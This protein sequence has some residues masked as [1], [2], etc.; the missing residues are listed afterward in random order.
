MKEFGD[1]VTEGQTDPQYMF[2]AQ[3]LSALDD[4]W[5][6]LLQMWDSRQQGL[7]Q[8]L[9]LQVSPSPNLKKYIWIFY[10]LT[11]KFSSFPYPSL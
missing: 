8:D 3:R 7:S 6:E 4:G 10:L 1:H 9:N 11:S 2:L 5:K